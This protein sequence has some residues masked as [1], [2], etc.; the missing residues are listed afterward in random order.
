MQQRTT[1][2][3]G[4]EGTTNA[5]VKQAVMPSWVIA[6]LV[7]SGLAGCS[8]VPKSFNPQQPIAPR[9]FSHRAFDEVVRDHVVDG[10]VDY[11]AIAADNRFEGYL[12]QL[13]RVDPVGLPTRR[14][15]LAFWINA[16]NAFAVK[17]I[18]DGYSPRTWFGQIKYFI[19]RDY[20]VGGERINLY[21]LERKV[22]IPDFREPRIH[23]A[24]V[25]ASMS[26]PKLQSWAY[27]ADKLDQQ[28]EQSAKAFINDPTRNRFDRQRKIAHLAKIF[29]WFQEDFVA[30]SG[31]LIN[32]VRQYV[33]DPDLARELAATP[34]E[35]QFLEYDW[36]LNGPPPGDIRHAALS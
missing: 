5:R 26:C 34:Y 14:D 11:P 17:G 33:M 13:N 10:V 30:H 35:V 21:D 12:R 22:L 8:T 28:L 23:F 6:L 16:Y 32:Y 20:Q 18:L 24:I 29:D 36:R 4:R 31:S 7:V 19:S 1:R 27:S 2:P 15:Q 3:F 25:C 9:D